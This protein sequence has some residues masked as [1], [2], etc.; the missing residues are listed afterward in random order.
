MLKN[1]YVKCFDWTILENE[2][3]IHIQMF[4]NCNHVWFCHNLYAM[5]LVELKKKICGIFFILFSNNIRNSDISVNLW[6]NIWKYA[7]LFKKAT[8]LFNASSLI[9][10][11]TFHPLSYS[12]LNVS[13]VDIVGEGGC[14]IIFFPKHPGLTLEGEVVALWLLTSLCTSAKREVEVAL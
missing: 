2:L 8:V 6:F 5:Y 3:E 4:N 13:T 12:M 10:W 14:Q 9:G 7:T 1:Q 11:L